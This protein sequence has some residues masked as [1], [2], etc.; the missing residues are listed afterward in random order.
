MASDLFPTGP[1]PSAFH[2]LLKYFAHP[3]TPEQEVLFGRLNDFIEASDNRIDVFLLKG[4]AG[5][6]KTSV[7]KA[8]AKTLR[9]FGLR[10][11]LLAP[12]GRAA[13]V[14]AHHTRRKSYTIHRQIYKQVQH[15]YSGSIEFKLRKNYQKNAVFVVDEASMISHQA[16]SGDPSMLTD[17]IQYVFHHPSNR[18]VIIGDPAQLPPV[19]HSSSAALSAEVLRHAY[20]LSVAEHQ[21]TEVVRHANQSGILA[22][23]TALRNALDERTPVAIRTRPYPD[24]FHMPEDRLKE[25]LSYA[26]LKYGLQQTLLISP[27]NRETV[28]YNQLIRQ[29]I[30][31]RR[32]VVEVGDLLMV[33]RNNYRA[34]PKGYPLTF[35]ANGEFVEVVEV[36]DTETRYGFDFMTL[37]LRLPDYPR[38]PPFTGKILLATLNSTTPSLSDG[39]NKQLYEAVAKDYQHI[40]APSRRLKA[41]RKDDYLNALQVKFAYALTGHKA[42]GGQWKCVFVAPDYLTDSPPTPDTIR[43]LYTAFTRA[44]DELYL[45]DFP[46]SY[47][48]V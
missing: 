5:T 45:I 42:Q 46:R 9:K 4:Y 25:G 31:H 6:G 38:Q 1:T 41:I 40:A 18:L 24:I 8:L 11:V 35:L 39:Q 17:L 2:Y 33:T 19:G 44:T 12:T 47:C 10:V 20:Q 28:R 22:N 34:L 27:S 37:E 23:A 15:P 14:V 3:P 29:S 43:W 36:G 32:Q 21:L 26:Y 48:W 30:L 16:R 13:K 7:I